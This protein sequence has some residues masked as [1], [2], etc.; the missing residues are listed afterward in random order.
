MNMTITTSNTQ[1]DLINVQIYGG[2]FMNNVLGCSVLLFLVY[3]RGLTW[4]FSA[5]VLVV[6]ITC[7]IM[8]LVV[9]F[10]SDFPLWTSFMAFLLY[11]FSLFL[12]YVFN[13]VLDYV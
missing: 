4:E 12:A 3:A 7:A 13:D 8:S 11:P 6:L 2:V 9:S 10:H 5:E 1:P